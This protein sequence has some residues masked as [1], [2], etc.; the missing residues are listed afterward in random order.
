M[1]VCTGEFLSQTQKT[2]LH[3]TEDRHAWVCILSS[4]FLVLRVS[5]FVVY[6]LKKCCGT[7]LYE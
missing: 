5:L 3:L 7:Y 2:L 6:S 1:C 4:S